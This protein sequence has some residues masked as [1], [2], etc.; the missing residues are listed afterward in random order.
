[1]MRKAEKSPGVLLR[2]EPYHKEYAE[3]H[4]DTMAIRQGSIG[5]GSRVVLVDD[6]IA[7]GGTAI[8]GF[9]LVE[10]SGAVVVEFAAVIGI[11]FLDGVAKIHSDAGGK[12]KDVP[13]FT[14]VHDSSITGKTCG[15]PEGWEAG[16]E[17][18]IPYS[19][20]IQTKE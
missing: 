12:Y 1:M 8:S 7:T 15:D 19:Q 3:T 13:V 2:S 16:K 10:A 6:L 14:L 18:V 4:P 9:Q 20:I 5:A 17:R 11:P